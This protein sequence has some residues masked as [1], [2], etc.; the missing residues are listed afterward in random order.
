LLG[1]CSAAVVVQKFASLNLQFSRLCQGDKAR[2]W[3]AVLPGPAKLLPALV[4][5]CSQLAGLLLCCSC[6]AKICKFK[7]SI[8][9]VVSGR[10]GQ[11]LTAGQNDPFDHAGQK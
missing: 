5:L 2:P 6:G 3:Q 8:F 1:C 4:L 7:S 10:Q 11:A 9:K